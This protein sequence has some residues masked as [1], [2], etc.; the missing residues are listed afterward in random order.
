MKSKELV[1]KAT[2]G[3]IG[4]SVNCVLW[5]IF[6]VGSSFGKSKTSYGAH[7][8]FC[9]ADEALRDFNYQAFKQVLDYMRRS[10][11]IERRKTYTGLELQVTALGKDRIEKMFPVYQ[12]NRLWNGYLYLVSYDIPETH[13]DVRNLLREYL[14]RIGCAMLQESLWLTPYTPRK[15]LDEF[16]YE[17]RIEGTI[18]L[19]KLGKDGTVGE[20]NLNRLLIRVYHLDRLNVRY[21][22][23]LEKVPS[24]RGKPFQLAV[25]YQGILKDDPQLPFAL[26]PA[27]WLGDKAF[28]VYEKNMKLIYRPVA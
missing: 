15:L 7:Q 3:L 17:H 26:L 10:M 12:R 1:L 25:C 19:S 2:D 27:D 5:F 24:M 14:Q 13:H 8:A 4:T 16:V 20:E 22:E 23:F 9:E 18:L 28:S 6:L 21:R 11:L